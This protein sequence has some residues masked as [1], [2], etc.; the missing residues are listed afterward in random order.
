[1]IGSLNAQASATV[2]S[3]ELGSKNTLES[4]ER[5]KRTGSTLDNIAKE[6]IN[7]TEINTSVA[8]ATREQTLATAE[9]SQNIV[10]IATFA[11]QTKDNMV[12]SE[13]LCKGLHHESNALKELIGRF[14]I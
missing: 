14:T 6:I 4:A 5:L 8:S 1:M 2:S 11:D 12:Q 10:M 9:I 13:E 3:I 7:L